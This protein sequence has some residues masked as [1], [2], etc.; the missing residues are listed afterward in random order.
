MVESWYR[1]TPEGFSFCPKLPG[2][3]THEKLLEGTASWSPRSR[4][5]SPG[6]GRSW[7]Q[8]WWSFTRASRYDELPKLEAFLRA[9]PEGFR[10]VVEFRHRSWL[11]K[12]EAL[13]LLRELKLGLAMAHHPWY[14]RFKEATTDFAYLRLLGRRDVFPDFTRVHQPQDKALQQWAE[15]LQGLASQVPRAFVFINNQFEGHSP[16][17]IARLRAMFEGPASA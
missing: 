5:P 15:V 2:E 8:S 13:A 17:T 7:D 10:Y 12:P 14:P 9:L 4:Q 1:R 3:I 16:S 11:G 6:W